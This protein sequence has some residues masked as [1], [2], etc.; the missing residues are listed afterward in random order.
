MHVIG[1]FTRL[2]I[3][4][5]PRI[6]AG[7]L[8]LPVLAQWSCASNAK[9]PPGDGKSDTL[10]IQHVEVVPMTV[11]GAVLSDV[12]VVVQQGRV[13]AIGPAG[14]V[15]IPSNATR[16]DGRGKWLMPGLADSHCH[17]ENDRELRL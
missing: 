16:F 15:S 8:L 12:T 13:A 5:M 6:L 3:H 2:A 14:A 17:I 11:G 1:S 7:V 4:R 10:A 9:P